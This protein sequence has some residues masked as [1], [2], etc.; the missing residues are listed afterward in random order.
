L[1][2]GNNLRYICMESMEAYLIKKLIILIILNSSN[3]KEKKSNN[4]TMERKLGMNS[5]KEVELVV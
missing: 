2:L 3:K 1:I 4:L 5:M